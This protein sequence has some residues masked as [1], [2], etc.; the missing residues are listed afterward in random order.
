LSDEKNNIQDSC[1]NQ[2][3]SIAQISLPGFGKTKKMGKS[4]CWLPILGNN[5]FFG[6]KK[7]ILKINKTQFKQSTSH[8]CPLSFFQGEGWG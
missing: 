5:K 6:L 8:L 7:T 1:K 3:S 4:H 2:Q